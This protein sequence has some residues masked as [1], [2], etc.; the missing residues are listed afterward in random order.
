MNKCI[1]FIIPVLFFFLI[2]I[3]TY[4]QGSIYYEQ[5]DPGYNSLPSYYEPD[6]DNP[7]TT[8][9]AADNFIVPPGEVWEIDEVE[10]YG[11][12]TDQD[13]LWFDLFIYLSTAVPADDVQL[14]EPGEI[15]AQQM[16]L[17]FEKITGNVE[18][19]DLYRIFLENP[20]ILQEGEYWLSLVAEPYWND[21]GPPGGFYWVTYNNPVDDLDFRCVR[22]CVAQPY[23]CGYYNDLTFRFRAPD[24]YA[25]IP[26]SDYSI[27]FG[28]LVM[29]L[30]TIFVV[31]RFRG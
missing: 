3:D 14:E 15:F 9:Q 22:S 4:A 21:A 5:M 30:F 29:L 12:E 20:L 1:S 31:R 25:T 27:L 19:P 13:M 16:E 10:L 24:R 7:L 6:I 18:E 28:V 23:W 17:G 11:V 8:Y 26:L 2:S